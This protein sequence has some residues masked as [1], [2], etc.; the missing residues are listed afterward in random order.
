MYVL[1]YMRKRKLISIKTIIK[2]VGNWVDEN[3]KREND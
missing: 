3:P 1:S 2:E